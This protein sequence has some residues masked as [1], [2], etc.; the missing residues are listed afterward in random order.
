M[1]DQGHRAAVQ[2]AVLTALGV[3][4]EEWPKQG[5]IRIQLPTYIPSDRHPALL[6]ALHATMPMWVR[7]KVSSGDLPIVDTRAVI[8]TQGE[9]VRAVLLQLTGPLGGERDE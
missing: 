7:V 9:D 8:D 5:L 3:T 6:A 1:F 2:A 4:I